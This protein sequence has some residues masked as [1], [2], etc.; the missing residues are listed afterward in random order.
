M[1]KSE[2]IDSNLKLIRRHEEVH[3]ILIKG[4]VNQESI[5]ILNIYAPNSGTSNFIKKKKKKY[6]W[7]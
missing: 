7:I 6:S 1:L 4:I 3:F 2:K 5:T